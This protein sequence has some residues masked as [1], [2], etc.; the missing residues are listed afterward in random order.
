MLGICIKIGE[1]WIC[2]ARFK[3]QLGSANSF[4]QSTQTRFANANQT[5][6]DEISRQ[7]FPSFSQIN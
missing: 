5:F 6:N 3:N 7:I 2:F 4:H 1:K